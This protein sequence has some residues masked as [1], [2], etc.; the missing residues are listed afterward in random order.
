MIRELSDLGK[1]NRVQQEDQKQIHNALKDEPFTIDL[2][3][4]KD[5]SFHKFEPIEKRFTRAEAITAKK[6]KARLLLDKAEEVLSYPGKDGK[7]KAKKKHSLFM[8]KLNEYKDLLEIKPVLDFYNDN[9]SKGVDN[10]LADFE[11]AIPE[12][13]RGGNIAFRLITSGNKRIHEEAG[14]CSAIIKKYEISEKLK[15][16]DFSTNSNP[17]S[18]NISGVP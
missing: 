12:K 17:K 10:A 13:E 11:Q 4:N 14:V 8:D 16:S 9:K 15:L 5:G 6:G 3:I 7:E 2:V 1:K 18:F